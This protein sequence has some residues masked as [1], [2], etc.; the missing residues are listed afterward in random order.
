M[1]SAYVAVAVAS[2]SFAH[3]ENDGLCILHVLRLAFLHWQGISYRHLALFQQVDRAFFPE[4]RSQIPLLR[5]TIGSA[6]SS[7]IVYLSIS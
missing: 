1:G 5:S 2:L 7:S 4:T 3:V 6:I